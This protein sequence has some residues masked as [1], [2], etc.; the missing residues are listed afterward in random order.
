MSEYTPSAKFFEDV[1]GKLEKENARLRKALEN[2]ERR[3][4]KLHMDSHHFVLGCAVCDAIK[5]AREIL[6]K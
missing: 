5:I 6:E 2:L 4:S 1:I 3:V